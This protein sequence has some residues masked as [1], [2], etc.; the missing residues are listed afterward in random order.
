MIAR[1]AK[2]FQ[3]PHEI[4]PPPGCTLNF[5]FRLIDLFVE[6]RKQDPIAQRVRD[7]FVRLAARLGRRPGRLDF[8]EGTDF[9]LDDSTVRRQVFRDGG[10]LGFL[11]QVSSLKPEE[12]PW[13]GS[14]AQDF[15]AVVETTSMSRSYKVPTLMAFL[16]DGR[17]RTE[18]AVEGIVPTWRSYYFSGGRGKDLERFLNGSRL[19]EVSDK[20]LAGHIRKNPVHFTSKTHGRF[21]GFDQDRDVFFLQ[22]EIHPWLDHCLA[23]HFMDILNLR[24]AQYFFRPVFSRDVKSRQEE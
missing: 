9:D 20:N 7:E 16:V 11:K 23:H 24:T 13:I 15:L 10:W 2:A 18:V 8:F 14:P 6:M 21:F 3:L 4:E 12:A 5:D 17:W 19:D 22:P 1:A